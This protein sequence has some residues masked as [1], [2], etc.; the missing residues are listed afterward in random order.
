MIAVMLALAWFAGALAA[1]PPVT[2]PGFSDTQVTAV[3]SPTALAFTP[4]GRM[5]VT[6]QSGQLRVYQNGTLTTALDLTIGNRICNNHERG[7]LGVA[8][9]PA[10]ALNQF[11]YLYYTFNKFPNG[12]CPDVQ[13]DNPDNPVN[14]VSRFVLPPSN[15]VDVNSET[16]LVD[17]IPSTNG[18]HNAGD[19]Q[20]GKDGNLYISIGDGGADYTRTNGQASGNYAARDK[21]ILLGKILRIKPDGSLPAD[22]PWMGAD[23]ARCYDPAPGGNKTARNADGKKCQETFAWGLRNPFRIA[24]DSNAASTRFFINDVGQ[25]TWEEIDEALAG[26]DYGWNLREGHCASGSGATTD[27]GPPPA[28]MTNPIFDY[29]HG[30]APNNCNAISGGAFVPNGLWP[31]EYDGTYLFGDYV[32]GRIFKLAPAGGGGYTRTDFITN[33]GAVIAL[34]FGPYAGGQA[35]YYTTFGG[36]G[37]VRRVTYSGAGNRSPTASIGANPTSGAAPLTVNFSASGSSDP[38]GDALTYDWDFGDATAHAT[39]PAPTHTYAAG[40]YTATLRVSDGKGGSDTATVRIDSGNTPPQPTITAPDLSLRFHVGQS[41]TLQGSAT[42]AQD[43]ALPPERLSW[44]AVLHHNDHTHP[45]LPPTPGNSVTIVA[46]PPEDLAATRTSYLEVELTATDSQG[47]TSVITREL[48]ANLVDLTFATNPTGLKVAANE[49][50]LTGPQ[51]VTS[52]QGFAINIGA[53]TQSDAQGVGWLFD[54]W[55][56]GGAATHTI[57]T[58][59]APAAYTATFRHVVPGDLSVRTYLPI[60]LR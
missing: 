12:N 33:V 29:Q 48:G 8:V 50:A 51:S 44:R 7:L 58:P 16:I 6:S 38:D 53:A 17:N 14:R 5:L 42:D 57:I 40:T 11:I 54:R 2:L 52:W 1:G 27:C 30:A 59:S 35:L 45:F 9:D 4:D 43:G 49:L 26:A 46:P 60:M 56:D 10:F 24:F 15:I 21:F 13:P 47:L 31:A 55:S 36:G 19:V 41:I 34:R 37:Q 32:C 20:F 23:S 22:N 39:T 25:G 3:G 28:G 18:N